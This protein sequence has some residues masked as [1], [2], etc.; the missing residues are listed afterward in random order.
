MLPIWIM[1]KTYRVRYKKKLPQRI[2]YPGSLIQQNFSE[3]LE[4]GYLLWDIKTAD[5]FESKFVPVE[6]DYGFFTLWA[7]EGKLPDIELPPK[8]RIRVVWPIAESD[9]SRSLVNELSQMVHDK[10]K[11]LSVRIDFKPSKNKAGQNIDID[12]MLDVRELNVQQDLLK[13]WLVANALPEDMVV[14]ILDIDKRI[15]DQVVNLEFD[16]FH[17]SVWKINSITI[18]DFMSYKGPETIDFRKLR[19]VVGLFGDNRSGKSVLIDAILYALFNKTTR[20]VKNHDLINKV[21]KSKKCSVQLNITIRGIEYQITRVTK[22]QFKKKSGEYTWTRTDLELKRVLPDGTVEDLTETQRN[23]TEKVIRN[24]IGSF[25]DFLTTTLT[26]QSSQHEFIYQNA[27]VRAENMARFLGLD[28]F[29]RKHE[30]AKE[31]LREVDSARKVHDLDAKSK[32]LVSTREKS[33]SLQK[34][35]SEKRKFHRELSTELRRR[36][37]MLESLRDSLNTAITVDK[38]REEIDA[39]IKNIENQIGLL[40]LEI[41]AVKGEAQQL[42]DEAYKLEQQ[43]VD[44]TQKEAKEAEQLQELLMAESQISNRVQALKEYARALR[45]DSNSSMTCPV[46]ELPETSGCIFVQRQ[47]EKRAELVDY[48]GKIEELNQKLAVVTQK[49]TLAREAKAKVDSNDALRSQIQR[50][51]GQVK[52][53]KSDIRAL[54]SKRDTKELAMRMLLDKLDVITK[55]EE[56][57]KSNRTITAQIEDIRVQIKK[58]QDSRDGVNDDITAASSDLAV[59]N[60]RIEEL[61]SLIADIATNDRIYEVYSWYVKAMH[62]NGI[63]ITVLRKYVPIINYELNRILSPIVGFGVYFKIEDG[64][65]NIEIVMRYDDTIDDTRSITMASGMEKF[66]ANMAIR[67]V[68]LKISALNKPTLRIIDEGFD[69]LDN[70]NVYLVQKFFESVKAEFDNVVIITHIDALKDCADHVVTVSQSNGISRLRL[71]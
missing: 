21:T 66:I 11:P 62:R 19:G 34:L 28:I 71:N 32:L 26:T 36:T 49:I 33:V 58:L 44:I 27:A 31:I 42:I 51:S 67:H 39:E 25:E 10:Y 3:D 23:E 4:K 20:G 29:N 13:K 22:M 55:N 37:E 69:V 1:Q 18:R 54:E 12:T 52:Q 40:N 8:C 65:E 5:D 17:Q 60:A 56:I 61:E 48:L 30:M 9:I 57:V 68:L 7:D 50:A 64:N 45:N 6:N 43:L 24:A 38:T 46:G 53:F 2:Q 59:A 16:D 70:D 41:E 15:F 63:P 47:A 14:E 35:L